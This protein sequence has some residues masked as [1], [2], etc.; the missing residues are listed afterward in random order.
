MNNISLVSFSMYFVSCKALSGFSVMGAQK[1]LII[2]III[3]INRR[4]SHGNSS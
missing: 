3:I 4:R 1:S 2:I